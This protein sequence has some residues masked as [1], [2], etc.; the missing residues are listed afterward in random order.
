MERR[1]VQDRRALG[2]A[3]T[4]F[5][6]TVKPGDTALFY[7]SGHG[8]EVDGQNYLL[9]TGPMH[10]SATSSACWRSPENVALLLFKQ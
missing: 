4:A 2:T 1:S 9:L 8:M 6:A 10:P 5:A 7:F 3:V